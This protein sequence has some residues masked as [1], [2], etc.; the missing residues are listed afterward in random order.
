MADFELAIHNAFE[1]NFRNIKIK[2]CQFHLYQCFKKNIGKLG[3]D[4]VYQHDID[5]RIWFKKMMEIS[6][7]H[8]NQIDKAFNNLMKDKP[9]IRHNMVW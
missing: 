6:F 9:I 3:L 4:T 1:A 2:G 5:A 7:I 8:P